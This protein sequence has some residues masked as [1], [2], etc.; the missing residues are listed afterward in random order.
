[1]SLN[2][3]QRNGSITTI[4]TPKNQLSSP[5]N[6]QKKTFFSPKVA[7]SPKLSISPSL[8]TLV[9]RSP[10]TITHF[11]SDSVS[12]KNEHARNDSFS[13]QGSQ[14]GKISSSLLHATK[15]S[16]SRSNSFNSLSGDSKSTLELKIV[17][18][19]PQHTSKSF[20][21]TMSHKTH[22]NHHLNPPLLTS[23]LTN[24]S[25]DSLSNNLSSH[26]N[27]LLKPTG[28]ITCIFSN[29]A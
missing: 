20:F 24:H 2:H 16:N 1:M 23:F 22:D 29:L 8:P 18:E 5:S 13:S 21:T 17:T 4:P 14:D 28:A 26:K 10:K 25:N 27:A 9:S 3:N 15:S 6:N 19:T 7:P 11:R 12:S